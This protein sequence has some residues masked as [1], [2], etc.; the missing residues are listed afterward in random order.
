MI[1]ERADQGDIRVENEWAAFTENIS[2]LEIAA[3]FLSDCSDAFFVLQRD[4][5][6]KA[7]HCSKAS[8]LLELVCIVRYMCTEIIMRLKLY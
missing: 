3:D 1:K 7:L 4:S 2:F 8:Y 5:D 6:R